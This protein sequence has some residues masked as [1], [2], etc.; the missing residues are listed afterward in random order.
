MLQ[1]AEAKLIE[2]TIGYFTSHGWKSERVPEQS[3]D[4]REVV[5]GQLAVCVDPRREDP[6]ALGYAIPGGVFGAAS[7]IEGPSY[8]HRLRRTLGLMRDTGIGPAVHGDFEHGP[9]QGCK[10]LD[11]LSRGLIPGGSIS[12][13]ELA[14][15]LKENEVHHMMFD[16]TSDPIG[17][18][19]NTI[20]DTTVVPRRRKYVVDPRAFEQIGIHPRR[21]IPFLEHVG[22]LLLPPE[23]RVL[24]IPGKK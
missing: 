13:D 23:R 17:M 15:L 12:Q 2:E 10:F 9:I 19:F 11:A 20:P 1:T 18:L 22:S 4:I 8:S 21:Y 16:G 5:S 7:L 6:L 14:R 24:I 3:L